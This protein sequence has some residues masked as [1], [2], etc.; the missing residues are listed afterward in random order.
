[1][2]RPPV[3]MLVVRA[4]VEPGSTAPLRATIRLTTDTSIGFTSELSLSD[5]D[6]VTDVVRGWLKEIVEG[7]GPVT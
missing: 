6:A 4:W 2:A 5:A 3:G 1:M 7:R